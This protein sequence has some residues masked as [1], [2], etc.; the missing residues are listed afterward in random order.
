MHLGKY[1]KGA[2][3]VSI[4]TIEPKEAAALAEGVYA[5][6]AGDDFALQIFLGNKLFQQ[7]QKMLK[8]NVGGRV[9]RAVE[10]SFGIAAIG[11]TEQR[12]EL[13]LIFRGTTTAN[14]KA[15]FITDARIGL[16]SSSSGWPVHIG[17]NHA[18]SS[19]I[20]DIQDFCS[21]QKGV[22]TVHC[23]GHS[24]GGAVA[25]LAADWAYSNI[26]K[27]VKLY[28]FGQP[29]VGLSM[30]ALNITRKLGAKNI[31]RVFH[32]TD[33]VPMVP[34]FPYVHNPLPGKGHSIDSND[35]IHVATA[36]K[37]GK[38]ADNVKNKRW[39][40]I[41]RNAPK[42]NH[43]DAIEGWLN[44]RRNENPDCP[45]TFEWVERA[46]HWLLAKITGQI[47]N[48]AHLAIMG[49]HTFLD[50]LAWMLAKAIEIKDAVS[51]F[52]RMFVRKV[53][54]VLGIKLKQAGEG[55]TRNFLRYILEALTRRA[56]ELAQ[57]AIR[58]LKS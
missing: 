18:F 24:L 23:V 6:N 33:P 29:R 44:S 36:H 47:V 58:N 16:T 7:D 45:K 25:T 5:V 32:T 22:S 38:Y 48:I 51:E 41:A 10:D 46:I 28:T 15:D 8:A 1:A 13:F 50:K 54:R 39:A 40:D 52:V 20:R 2:I 14:N 35:L 21:S 53:A 57:R 43:E 31:R 11:G 4:G 19:M 37:M 34:V 3:V 42:F 12:K 27:D 26:A 17:F 55:I 9:F 56:Y 30:H 49:V